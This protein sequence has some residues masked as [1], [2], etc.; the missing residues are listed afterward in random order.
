MHS[1]VCINNSEINKKIFIKKIIDLYKHKNK[2][3]HS[4]LN[5]ILLINSFNEWGENMAFEPSDKYKYY[6]LNLLYECLQTE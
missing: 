2:N 3:N 5:N 4:E 6:Y 1:T